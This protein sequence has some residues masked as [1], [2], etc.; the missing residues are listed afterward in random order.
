MNVN[1]LVTDCIR[2]GLC[3]GTINKY[4]YVLK[5]SQKTTAKSIETWSRKDFE[6]LFV[7][8]HE[9]DWASDTKINRWATLKKMIKWYNRPLISCFDDFRLK[10]KTRIKTYDEILT[11]DEVNLM[12]KFSVYLRTKAMIAL[13][14]ETGC[15][16]GE[17]KNLKVKSIQDC[18]DYAIVTLDGKTGPRTI[19]IVQC[20]PLLREHLRYHLLRNS[21]DAP[22]FTSINKKFGT[23]PLTYTGIGKIVKEAA[24]YAGIAK[25]MYPYILRHSRVSHMDGILSDHEKK[26]YFGWTQSSVM[27]N[28]YTHLSP[29]SVQDKILQMNGIIPI[30]KPVFILDKANLSNEFEFSKEVKK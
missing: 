22:L 27:P 8:F 7:W 17:L 12:I 19:P 30:K 24:R 6:K 3:Q 9:A 1:R 14:Y 5:H 28:V 15:R 16:P 21:P 10:L 26:L 20:L 4:V 25:R 29:R 18:G 11:I 2:N 23:A 13:M